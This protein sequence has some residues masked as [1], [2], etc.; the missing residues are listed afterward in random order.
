MSLKLKA[1]FET[2]VYIS[3]GGYLTIKQHND[4][5]GEGDHVMLTPE[6][7]QLVCKEMQMLLART[8]EWWTIEEAEKE[9]EDE[10][11][12]TQE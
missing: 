12:E 4:D 1:A 11:S 8:D 5:R 2:E 9:E 7:A 3:N 6:Q 10:G